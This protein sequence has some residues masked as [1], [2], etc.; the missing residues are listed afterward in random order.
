MAGLGSGTWTNLDQLANLMRPSAT[1][2]PDRS[3]AVRWD[4][5]FRD[6]LD[7]TEAVLALHRARRAT[8]AGAAR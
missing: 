2:D 6:W 1:I 8:S 5:A 4:A 7:A 3:S